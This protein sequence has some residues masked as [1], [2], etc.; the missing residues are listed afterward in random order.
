MMKNYYKERLKEL[1]GKNI[2][3]DESPKTKEKKR[4]D[5]FI[6]IVKDI[7]NIH[8]RSIGLAEDY[9][10]ILLGYE[11]QYF[12]IIED[13]IVEMWGETVAFIIFW[14]IYEVTNPKG[15][16]NIILDERSGIEYRVNSIVQVYNVLKKIKAFK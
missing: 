6:Q 2:N 13:L 9:N 3:A 11:D 12:Q 10:I 4:K 14:W 15:E 16:E 5:A 7:Q 8:N 1:G